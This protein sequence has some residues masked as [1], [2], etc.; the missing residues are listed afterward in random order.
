MGGARGPG[1]GF[2]AHHRDGAG[3]CRGGACRR[4]WRRCGDFHGHDHGLHVHRRVRPRVVQPDRGDP[5]H[6]RQPRH[7]HDRDP[8]R[9]VPAPR[10]PSHA[11][12]RERRRSRE[13]RPPNRR[14]PGRQRE[15]A[16][17][18]LRDTRG[19]QRDE[20]HDHAVRRAGHRRPERP[21]RD[22]HEQLRRDGYDLRVRARE[23]RRRLPRQRRLH[24][25]R[26]HA[27]RAQR[28][29]GQRRMGRA[30]PVGRREQP[31]PRQQDRAERRR[32]GR[33]PERGRRNLGPQAR[34]APASGAARRARGTPSVATAA[35]ASWSRGR[36]VPAP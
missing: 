4:S 11:G 15:R 34:R 12:Q 19:E 14:L 7:G 9:D 36:R 31:D 35:P 2:S 20:R 29:L 1:F 8:E 24:R 18:H 17:L 30:A 27:R 5:G 23:R 28:D 22:D 13:P 26:R 33:A 6:E 21:G 10:R 16:P 25:G 32:L 3:V